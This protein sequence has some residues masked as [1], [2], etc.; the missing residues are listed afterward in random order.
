MMCLITAPACSY[1]R[2]PAEIIQKDL[3][4]DYVSRATAVLTTIRG[5][6]RSD[7]KTLGERFGSLA[8]L[9]QASEMELKA[10][11]GIGATKAGRLYET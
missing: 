10:C 4:N 8:N 5:V 7:V 11:P 1:E 9:F 2:K 3:G 6:N